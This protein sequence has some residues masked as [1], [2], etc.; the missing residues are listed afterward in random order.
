MT[1]SYVTIIDRVCIVCGTQ[2]STN[3]LALDKHLRAKYEQ[4]TLGGWGACDTHQ[5]L[6]DD[7][8]VALVESEPPMYG[9]KTVPPEDAVRLGRIVHIKKNIFEEMFDTKLSTDR[10]PV[11]FVEAELV[12]HIEKLQGAMA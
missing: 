11:C 1:K 2:Y 8:Y 9:N 7:E 4:H 3:E 6:A 5:K 10:F 12:D